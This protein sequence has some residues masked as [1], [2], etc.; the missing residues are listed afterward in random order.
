MTQHTVQTNDMPKDDPFWQNYYQTGK[1][2]NPLVQNPSSF[3]TFVTNNLKKK[4]GSVLELGC[5]NGRDAPALT[6]T[7]GGQV[8]ER[9]EGEER[10]YVGIDSCP[11]AIEKARCLLPSLPPSTK[12][13]QVNFALPYTSQKGLSCIITP[14]TKKFEMVYSR[15]TLHSVTEPEESILFDNVGLVLVS[16]G[17]FCIEARSRNDPR[18]GKG[19]EVFPHAFVDTHFR[20]FLDLKETVV[21]LESR[22]FN[23]VFACEEWKDA[24]YRDDLAVVIRILCTKQ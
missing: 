6:S 11:I 20:R 7:A 21:K 9:G 5:G 2:D 12:F 19:E 15:F 17:W 16:G 24:N 3:A 4:P 8:Q 23:I 14:K 18:Y 13:H 1:G 22:G 10:Q